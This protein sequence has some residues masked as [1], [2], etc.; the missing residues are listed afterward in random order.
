M[1]ASQQ[2]QSTNRVFFSVGEP[3]GDL[4]GANLIRAL[5]ERVPELEVRGMGGPRMA[6]AGLDTVQDLT[7]LAVMGIAQVIW[8][9]HRFWRA[10][11]RVCND[12]DRHRPDAVVLIDFPGFN[13]WVARAAKRRG[14]PVFY[15]G[16]PQLWAWGRWRL[17]KMKRLVDHVLCKLPFEAEWYQAQGVQAHYVGHPY[18][19]ELLSQRLDRDFLRQLQQDEAP[20]VTLLPGSRR[21]EVRFNLPLLLRAARAVSEQVHPIR[22][23]IAGFN[24]EQ[25]H[26]AK[27]I[28]AENQ[29]PEQIPLRIDVRKTAELIAGADACI[30]CSGSVS[31]ELLFHLRP[32]VVVYRIKRST[33]F[34]VRWLLLKVRYITLVNLLACEDRFE[35]G[36]GPYDASTADRI[37]VPY[38]E[39]AGYWDS[40]PQ[41]AHHIV[42]WLTAPSQR[43][44]CVALLEPL[45][46]RMAEAGA[47]HRAASYI[48]DQLGLNPRA[49]E[50]AA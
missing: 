11:K 20:L 33:W 6:A 21:Q 45:R 12:L 23:A 42:E 2:S 4:H 24:D 49:T 7:Q 8:N 44:A 22:F 31:L 48:L 27:E 50:A 25:A 29:W 14:I 5:K 47:S 43:A 19:D 3:S 18:F 9:I 35:V 15:Y 16:V 17:A 32:A 40:S 36:K 1:M 30:A 39:Y 41:V 46:A 37:R 10:W 28:V 38:P 34:L 13:W 26:M